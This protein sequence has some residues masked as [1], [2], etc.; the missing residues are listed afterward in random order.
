[1]PTKI[2]EFIE[3]VRNGTADE[4]AVMALWHAAQA[5][6]HREVTIDLGEP[7]PGWSLEVKE[8]HVH[9]RYVV[10]VAKGRGPLSRAVGA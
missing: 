3:Q 6:G 10:L 7:L 5:H 9:S 4:G 8:H 1:M 2:T